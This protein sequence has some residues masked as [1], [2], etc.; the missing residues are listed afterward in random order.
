MKR[1]A[2]VAVCT[3]I[4]A[5]VAV[6][7]AA[8]DPLPGR[9]PHAYYL[10]STC[11]G[12]AMTVVIPNDN[13]R[14]SFAVDSNDVGHTVA[15]AGYLDPLRTQELFLDVNMRGIYEGHANIDVQRCDFEE[16]IPGMGTL[17]LRVWIMATTVL[18]G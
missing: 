4:L 7:T 11:G 8:A 10:P 6:A 5:V 18:H 2:F 12:V 3:A 9:S 1:L 16:T 17:Y 15:L 13:A 14:A